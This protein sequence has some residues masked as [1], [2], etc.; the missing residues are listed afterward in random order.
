MSEH[1]QF[2]ALFPGQGS[3]SP[4]M[5]SDLQNEFPVVAETFSEAS[6]IL[7]YDLWDLCENGPAEKQRQTQFTQPLMYCSGIA[8]WR[9]WHSISEAKPAAIAGHSLGEFSALTAAGC[10]SFAEGVSLVQKRSQLMATAVPE[11]QGGMAAV[12]GMD[13]E[14][15]IQLCTSL[16]GERVVEAVNFNAPGQVAVSGHL[17][18]VD[19]L[20][21]VAREHGAR[22]AIR[23]PV[24]V[25]NHS[26]LMHEAG[27]LLKEAFDAIQWQAP[28]IPI[29]Q[30]LQA[31]VPEGLDDL[32]SM[33]DQHVYSPVLW[34][35]SV[36]RIVDDFQPDFFIEMGPG[37]VLAGL[38]K[39]IDK[40]VP[41][42]A[43]DSAGAG[44][45]MLEMLDCQ[46]VSA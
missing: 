19:Q 6:D 11:G 35:Q 45:E 5:L 21:A 4:G 12:L 15:L 10:L 23:L 22:K 16:S 39:R 33:L 13:D 24:S 2:A 26:T 1:I 29:V 18:A 17:D 41:V 9:V 25:P 20:V 28:R 30:N 42:K 14:A 27:E 44:H 8:T 37:K 36:K 43:L 32:R 38:G 31:R 46:G 3:Q 34:T 7:G 40:S